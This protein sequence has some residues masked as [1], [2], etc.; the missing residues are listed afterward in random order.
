MYLK[1]FQ[2]MASWST[3]VLFKP[4]SKLIGGF[5]VDIGKASTSIGKKLES[6]SIGNSG[7][8]P[9]N[10]LDAT[11]K[12]SGG[13]H[14]SPPKRAVFRLL[15]FLPNRNGPLA[16]VEPLGGVFNERQPTRV[17]WV[18][19]PLDEQASPPSKEQKGSP[20]CSVARAMFNDGQGRG[21]FCVVKR[22]GEDGSGDSEADHD[23]AL[24]TWSLSQLFRIDLSQRRRGEDSTLA[25]LP[26]FAMQ[27]VARRHIMALRNARERR[28]LIAAGGDGGEASGEATEAD[29]A[30]QSLSVSTRAMRMRRARVEE[31]K[32]KKAAAEAESAAARAAERTKWCRAL[33]FALYYCDKI[34]VKACFEHMES[35]GRN[36]DGGAG[37][38]EADEGHGVARGDAAGSPPFMSPPH[39]EPLFHLQQIRPNYEAT[40]I[41]TK[42]QNEGND[43]GPTSSIGGDTDTYQD[44]FEDEFEDDRKQYQAA[45][46]EDEKEEREIQPN[47]DQQLPPLKPAYLCARLEPAGCL[48]SEEAVYLGGGST[49]LPV[50]E[51]DGEAACAN[52]SSKEHDDIKREGESA[53]KPQKKPPFTFHRSLSAF[54]TT[55]RTHGAITALQAY[56]CMRLLKGENSAGTASPDPPLDDNGEDVLRRWLLKR[57]GGVGLDGGG[58]DWSPIIGGQVEIEVPHGKEW[59]FEWDSIVASAAEERR[60]RRMR[61]R[62]RSAED[63][64]DEE[65]EQ[66][67]EGVVVVSRPKK[68]TG[69]EN[70]RSGGELRQWQDVEVKSSR[71]CGSLWWKVRCI[72]I[73][74]CLLTLLFPL[75]LSLSLSLMRSFIGN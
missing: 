68:E 20:L 3:K 14:R 61:A 21:I 64:S 49:F 46:E 55:K 4:A 72:D 71:D 33:W 56:D 13:R 48:P 26:P 30:S 29:T 23:E 60:K 47:Q 37:E 38:G 15:G 53:K 59:I 22:R 42:V 31:G 52:N 58:V 39:R 27:E 75:S 6:G 63:S 65:E 41:V 62:F 43:V 36:Q 19:P 9:I 54:I 11:G 35:I 18:S 69:D 44:D 28:E 40:A 66:Q 32:K 45:G 73:F 1:Y 16:T 67:K 17:R 24:D 5:V 50:S 25:L 7:S 8:G 57:C 2:Q 51:V 70:W 12:S 74:V 10:E 34:K